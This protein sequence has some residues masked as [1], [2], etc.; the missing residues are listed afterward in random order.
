MEI[1][2]EMLTGL[3]QPTL[4]EVDEDAFDK[5]SKADL[6]DIIA[7]L[8]REN[9]KAWDVAD[10]R[11]E[12]KR[13]AYQECAQRLREIASSIDTT[14]VVGRHVVEWML[15]EAKEWGA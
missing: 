15:N 2:Q 7:F 12:A 14:K 5:A 8:R 3:R 1:R 11:K 10:Q 13:E 4:Q 9:E 6:I